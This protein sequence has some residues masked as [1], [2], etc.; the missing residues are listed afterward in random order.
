VKKNQRTPGFGLNPE[1]VA[2]AV[3]YAI[4]TP[5]HDAISEILIRP[6]KQVV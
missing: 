2:D 3:A 4:G 1:D 5:E 6:T